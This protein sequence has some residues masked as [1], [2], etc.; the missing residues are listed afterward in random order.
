MCRPSANTETSR[1]TREK[2]LVPGVPL[3]GHPLKTDTS[4]VQTVFFVSGKSLGMRNSY[5]NGYTDR[6]E[7][8][9]EERR[10]KCGG[11]ACQKSKSVDRVL[12]PCGPVTGPGVPWGF[13]SDKLLQGQLPKEIFCHSNILTW[14]QASALLSA[15]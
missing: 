2:P 11:V 12:Y 8:K 14:R 9:D 5:C 6:G 15:L 4:L 13:S 7:S 1:R 3:Y 10:I